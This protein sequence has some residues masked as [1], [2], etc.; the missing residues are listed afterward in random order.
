MDKREYGIL[1]LRLEFKF[2]TVFLSV[3]YFWGVWCG[4]LLQNELIEGS[5]IIVVEIVKCAEGTP[6]KD[7][8][9]LYLLKKYDL[10]AWRSCCKAK[11]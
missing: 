5:L 9:K 10:R 6:L 2:F 7:R 3:T 1:N 4:K 11:T 8:A